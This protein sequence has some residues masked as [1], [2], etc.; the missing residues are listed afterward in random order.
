M[1][2]SQNV[3]N[4]CFSQQLEQGYNDKSIKSYLGSKYKN[5]SANPRF[6]QWEDQSTCE[7]Y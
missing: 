1:L 3:F 4:E 7:D 2:E 5:T 6:G